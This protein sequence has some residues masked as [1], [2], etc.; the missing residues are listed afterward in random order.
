MKYIRLFIVILFCAEGFSGF[1]QDIFKKDNVF[2]WC[3]VPFD[4][5]ERSPEQRV[6]MLKRLGIN[7]YA[8]DWR[9]KHLPEMEE[10]WALAARAGIRIQAVWLWIDGKSDSPEKLSADN[11]QMLHHLSRSGLKTQIWV[12]FNGN[13]FEGL[14]DPEKVAKG[15]DMLEALHKRAAALGCKIALY[16]H[17]DWF[18][19]PANQIKVI[20][21]ARLTDV[22]IIYNFHHAHE[23]LKRYKKIIRTTQP[24][25]WAVNLNGMREKGPKIL[26]LAAGDRELGMMQWLVKSGYKGPIGVLGHVED[27]DVEQVLSRNLAGMQQLLVEMR[28]LEAAATYR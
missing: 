19:E 6:D 28:A 25:L 2:A 22:G 1:T 20:K 10:E 13:Y 24:Y 18:G 11:E 23:Q 12:G 16:N 5:R 17:G 26:P 7:S 27:A 21:A 14:S 15:V 4:S 8:Y 3:I 9:S